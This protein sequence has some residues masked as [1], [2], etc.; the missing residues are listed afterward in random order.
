MYNQTTPD[1]LIDF[2]ETNYS[3]LHVL[4]LQLG[5]RKAG[6]LGAQKAAVNFDELEKEAKMKEELK[7]QMEANQKLQVAQTKEQREKQM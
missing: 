4:H 3:V 5:A 2:S 6:G 1:Y 7:A